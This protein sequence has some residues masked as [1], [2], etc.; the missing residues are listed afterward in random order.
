MLANSLVALLVEWTADSMDIFQVAVMENAPAAMKVHR[1][2][3][4][5]KAAQKENGKAAL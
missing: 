5:L 2:D 4:K 1:W 3:D